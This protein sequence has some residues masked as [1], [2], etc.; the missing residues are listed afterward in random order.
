MYVYEMQYQFLIVGHIRL[1]SEISLEILAHSHNL[2]VC[3]LIMDFNSE[4]SINRW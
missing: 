4:T 1:K 2:L 3:W